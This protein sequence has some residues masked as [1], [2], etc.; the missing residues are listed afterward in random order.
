MQEQW[1]PVLASAAR[2]FMHRAD[3]NDPAIL[4][5]SADVA[6]AQRMI[7]RHISSG[8]DSYDSEEELED[9]LDRPGTWNDEG[10]GAAS[11]Y[12]LDFHAFG[13][14]PDVD[15]SSESQASVT[16]DSACAPPPPAP[17]HT[18]T[19][20]AGAQPLHTLE[21][22]FVS[23]AVDYMPT[24]GILDLDL[25][26]EQLI[27]LASSL[28][29][30]LLRLGGS[31]GDATVFA[32][33]PADCAVQLAAGHPGTAAGYVCKGPPT[34]CLTAVRWEAWLRF[35][36]RTGLRPVLGLNGCFGRAGRDAPLNLTNTEALLAF[37][38]SLPWQPS[39]AV[40]LGNEL[41]ECTA[42]AA[43]W[44]PYNCTQYSTTRGASAAV[45]RGDASALAGRIATLW[46]AGSQ[47]PEVFGP[48]SAGLDTLYQR[49]A[50]SAPGL[51]ALT[52]HQYPECVPP[53]WGC[54]LANSTKECTSYGCR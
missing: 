44:S 7:S 54:T 34:N 31:A 10:A 16:P 48:D 28:A 1:N 15:S 4:H 26:D 25:E 50:A 5:P 29:P 3:P 13:V 8:S 41:S 6:G 12:E 35:A 39:F 19:V 42:G 36:N 2:G 52:Y 37:T 33:S 32:R 49:A 27:R 40:E 11:A 45:W 46:P 47:Q 51:A 21:P 9:S 43:R 17:L 38:R 53:A 20:D 22:S 18:L 24:I 23:V 30:G 14:L